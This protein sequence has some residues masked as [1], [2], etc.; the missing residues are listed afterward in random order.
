MLLKL[1]SYISITYGSEDREQSMDK[2]NCNLNPN[3]PELKLGKLCWVFRYG[4]F[5]RSSCGKY[6]MGSLFFIGKFDFIFF[7]YENWEINVVVVD[8]C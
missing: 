2:V 6:D 7:I 1:N 8:Y 4:S 5:C 3:I